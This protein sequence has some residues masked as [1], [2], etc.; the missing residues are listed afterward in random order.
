MMQVSES[1]VAIGSNDGAV[2]ARNGN[3]Y[4]V[5]GQVKLNKL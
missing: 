4:I 2:T 3:D 5:I 1:N